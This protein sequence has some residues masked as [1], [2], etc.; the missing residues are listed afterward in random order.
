LIFALL[1]GACGSGAARSDAAAGAR[2][3]AGASGGAAGGS[4][5]AEAG[6]GG[7]AGASGGAG[8]GGG[9]GASGGA[10]AGGSAG[11]AGGNAGANGGAGMADA[12]S[13][14]DAWAASGCRTSAAPP[15]ALIAD[16]SVQDGGAPVIPL[17]TTFAFGPLDLHPM[18]EDNAWHLQGDVVTPGSGVGISFT[19]CT[20]VRAYTGVAFS[21]RN[22]GPRQCRSLLSFVDTA[23]ATAG[24]NFANASGPPGATPGTHS[25]QT[26]VGNTTATIMVPFDAAFYT[27]TVANPS[28]PFDPAKLIG[29]QWTFVGGGTDA[30]VIDVFI[31]DVSFY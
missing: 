23:H 7:G 21:L 22:A 5:G 15:S 3:G 19:T 20:D 29:L 16:F 12:G 4:A 10:A 26:P 11:S 8:A 28:T 13:D 24:G 1:A 25:F 9:A 6:A 31:D 18:V 30:C 2:G 14:A 17:G 27:Y